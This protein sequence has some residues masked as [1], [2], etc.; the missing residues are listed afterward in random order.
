VDPQEG[1]GHE[2]APLLLVDYVHFFVLQVGS[3]T[4]PSLD[5]TASEAVNK[6]YSELDRRD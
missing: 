6:S 3:G 4:R 2:S 5:V 1:A